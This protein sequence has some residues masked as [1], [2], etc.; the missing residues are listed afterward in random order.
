MSG[1]TFCF[2]DYDAVGVD[3][4]HTICKYKLDA[5]FPVSIKSPA[6]KSPAFI[7]IKIRVRV[8]T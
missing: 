5:L 7:R 1:K 8:R 6:F 4:D 2:Q 3:L